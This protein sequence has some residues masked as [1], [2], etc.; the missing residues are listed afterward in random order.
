MSKKQANQWLVVGRILKP[1]QLAG[2][3]K[4]ESYCDEP[5]DIFQY[6][7]WRVGTNIVN[8]HLSH[9][10]ATHLIAQIEGVNH[11][12][13]TQPLISH[14]I[15]VLHSEIDQSESDIYWHELEGMTAHSPEG[16]HIGTLSGLTR[17]NDNDIVIIT[18]P[19][20]HLKLIPYQKRF[21]LNVDK[22]KRIITIDW[23][24]ENFDY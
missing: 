8:A 16:K 20:G 14:D 2:L 21:V 17:Q 11:I 12:D 9:P 15:E 22:V 7:S 6:S 3:V 4:I 13:D 18:T 5:H 23:P 19:S 1:F 24:D 10:N